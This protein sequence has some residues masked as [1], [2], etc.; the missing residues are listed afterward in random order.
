MKTQIELLEMTHQEL[1]TSSNEVRSAYRDAVNLD[2]HNKV[3]IAI[4]HGFKHIQIGTSGCIK[5]RQNKNGVFYSKRNGLGTGKDCGQYSSL[6]DCT[7]SLQGN[8]W[9][10]EITY[11]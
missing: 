4:S 2:F 7:K 3:E 6:R 5:V 1:M 8:G 11:K 9:G 10:N